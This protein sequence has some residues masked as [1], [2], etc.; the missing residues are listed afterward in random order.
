M[1]NRH[2]RPHPDPPSPRTSNWL[3]IAGRESALRPSGTNS[4]YPADLAACLW[5]LVD[6]TGDAHTRVARIRPVGRCLKAVG[7]VKNPKNL[8]SRHLAACSIYCV[9]A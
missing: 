2:L 5:D 3:S 4:V 1:D 7:M 9:A 6:P 8:V